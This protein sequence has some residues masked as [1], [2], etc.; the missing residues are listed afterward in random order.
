MKRKKSVSNVRAGHPTDGR[1][2]HCISPIPLHP[3]KGEF[4]T[5]RL[6]RVR[7]MPSPDGSVM[8]L[9]AVC[10]CRAGLA[11][12]HAACKQGAGRAAGGVTPCAYGRTCHAGMNVV[13]RASKAAVATA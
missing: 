8:S 6:S 3:P 1:H 9:T 10:K 7:D 13:S 11:G 4:P 2:A 12:C 5:A